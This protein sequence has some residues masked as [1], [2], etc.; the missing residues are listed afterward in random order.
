MTE[1]TIPR[2]RAGWRAA[3]LATLAAALLCGA[4][5]TSASAN[6]NVQRVSALSATDSS[7]TKYVTTPNCPSGTQLIGTGASIIGG[8]R[9]VTITG[10]RPQEAHLRPVAV[11]NVAAKASED[12]D[13]TASDWQLK[14]TAICGHVS[15]VQVVMVEYKKGLQYL[16]SDNTKYAYAYCPDGKRV[17]GV[18]GMTEFAEGRVMM[19]TI[20]PTAGLDGVEVDAHEDRYGTSESWGLVAY[21]ICADQTY[22]PQRVAAIGSD[23]LIQRAGNT[24]GKTATAAC[25]SGTHLLGSGGQVDHPY[26]DGLWPTWGKLGLTEIGPNSPSDTSTA[27]AFEDQV[28]TDDDW[29]LDAYAICG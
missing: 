21:A 7:S 1:I 4:L 18:G 13:G 10:L 28:G 2:R 19:D 17:L 9:Q 27:T 24:R 16:N 15:G 6:I 14:V 25:P 8:N 23:Y 12:W 5:A 11:T 20:A 22:D 26:V 29:S 3:A